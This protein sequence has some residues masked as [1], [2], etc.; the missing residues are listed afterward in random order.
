MLVCDRTTYELAGWFADRAR[1]I[2]DFVE[3]T[4]IPTLEQHGQEPT[5]EVADRMA[6][7]NL[8]LCLTSFSLAHSQARIVA[9]RNGARFLSLP[10]YSTELLSSP[11]VTADFR[12][13][14]DNVRRVA[15]AFTEGERV[16][17]TADAGTNVR[18]DV[19]GRIGNACPGWV[20]YPGDLGSPPDVE[21]NI[22]PVEDASHGVLV[23]DGSVT[24]PE[25][26][27]LNQ[28]LYLHI[29]GGRVRKI[30]GGLEQHRAFLERTFECQASRRRVLAEC[31]VGLNPLATLTGNMLTDEGAAGCV[32]FG[33]GSNYTVGG[34][35]EVDFHLDFVIRDAAIAVDGQ[36]L[37]IV[38]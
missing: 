34:Q 21:A 33:F 14:T 20:E 16:D 26:G 6:D 4:T 35:N 18:L 28:P 32:H 22:S 9:G 8:I 36:P 24:C 25:I 37:I 19:S 38:D 15:S 31:G 3:L 5:A 17:V 27:V 12:A 2:T 10:S 23:V 13:L 11:A 1:R 7:A 30:E 29:E